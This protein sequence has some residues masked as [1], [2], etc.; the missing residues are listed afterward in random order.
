VQVSTKSSQK[1][2]PKETSSG[3]TLEPLSPVPTDGE[4]DP[5]LSKKRM[6]KEK[7]RQKILAQKQLLVQ[8][9]A[10]IVRLKQKVNEEQEEQNKQKNK[11]N[12]NNQPNKQNKENKQPKEMKPQ[13]KEKKQNNEQSEQKEKKNK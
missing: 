4:T 7:I 1:E 10:E 12:H 8:Q 9:Q 6:K 11:A 13:S 2:T 5:A 3:S